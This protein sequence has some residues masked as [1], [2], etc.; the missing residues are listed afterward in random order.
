MFT[1]KNKFSFTVC[2]SV[3]YT[4]KQLNIDMF[5]SHSYHVV[6]YLSGFNIELESFSKIL[7]INKFYELTDNKRFLFQ[8]IPLCTD[9]NSRLDITNRSKSAIAMKTLFVLGVFYKCVL[10]PKNLN[11]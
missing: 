10:F 9:V 11:L 8:L 7:K 2:T 5:I 6:L 4:R 1:P 3:F